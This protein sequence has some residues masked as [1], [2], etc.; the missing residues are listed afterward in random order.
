MIYKLMTNPIT[1]QVNT[2]MLA[3]NDS[4]LIF[5]LDN[6]QSS[7]YKNF[8]ADILADK[9]EL[10]DADGNTMT[11]EQAKEFVATLP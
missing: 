10:Q 2:V 1:N 7:A 9:A 6:L 4:V 5:G 11:P 3:L 8:K